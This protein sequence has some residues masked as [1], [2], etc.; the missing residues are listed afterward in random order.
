[1][2]NAMRLLE[3]G[4]EFQNM[5]DQLSKLPVVELRIIRDFLN[6]LIELKSKDLP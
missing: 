6:E 2:N 5:L 4:Y 1:M 3:L